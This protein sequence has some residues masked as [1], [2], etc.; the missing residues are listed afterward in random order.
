MYVWKCSL[1]WICA[2]M[3][4]DCACCEMLLLLL[5]PAGRTAG[6]LVS[7]R[8]SVDLNTQ[9]PLTVGRCRTSHIIPHRELTSLAVMLRLSM[10][11]A[12]IHYFPKWFD[13]GELVFP[14]HIRLFMPEEKNDYYCCLGD[15]TFPTHHLAFY[16]TFQTYVYYELTM[17]LIIAP[18]WQTVDIHIR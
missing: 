10:I 6:P 7:S 17:F 16:Y 4:E 12:Q 15:E 3:V 8:L 1:V 13:Q 9:P 2:R 18:R 14:L 5:L 11:R